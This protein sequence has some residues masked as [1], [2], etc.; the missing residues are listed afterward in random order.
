MHPTFDL[1]FFDV[2]LYTALVVLGAVSGLIVTFAFL[3]TRARRAARVTIFLDGA[4]IVLAAGWI[5]ARAY[6]VALH[7]DYYVTRPDEIAQIGLGGLAMRGAFLTGLAALAFYARVRGLLFARLADAGALGLC[8]GQAIG[9]AGALSWGANYGVISDSPI[10]LDL[11]DAYGL[12]AP[13]FP[14]QYFEIGLFACLFVGLV[15]LA[16]YHPP[17]GTLFLAYWGVSAAAQ[18]AL[19]ALRGDETLL[20]LGWRFD[21]IVDALFTAVVGGIVIARSA[22]SRTDVAI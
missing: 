11:P 14:L 22:R 6:H 7:W 1:F 16:G 3:R 9:W 18:C 13:R 12:I 5:G 2:P 4:L 8:V 20:V 15:V 21:Q 17:A 19:G 10:A